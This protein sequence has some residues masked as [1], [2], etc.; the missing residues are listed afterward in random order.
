L[1][2]ILFLSFFSSLNDTK[3]APH[4]LDGGHNDDQ[5]DDSHDDDWR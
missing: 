4:T 3:L 2:L 1:L 5:D